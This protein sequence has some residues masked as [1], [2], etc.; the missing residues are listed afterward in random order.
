M[1]SGKLQSKLIKF[2]DKTLL[3]EIKSAL[4]LVD[5]E[6]IHSFSKAFRFK[7][8]KEMN[9]ESRELDAIYQTTG[10]M[11]AK[12]FKF[13]LN[14]KYYSTSKEKEEWKDCI[15]LMGQDHIIDTIIGYMSNL[16]KID[17]WN[18]TRFKLIR[19]AESYFKNTNTKIKKGNYKDNILI[20]IYFDKYKENEYDEFL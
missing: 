16:K 2:L 1:T 8:D 10:D 9:K 13:K 11:P 20:K 18:I 5:R 6:K 4:K 12:N 7:L 3:K 15:K 14:G 19:D 17:E